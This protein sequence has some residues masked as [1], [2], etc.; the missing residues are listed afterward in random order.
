MRCEIDEE[1]PSIDKTLAPRRNS[2]ESN[3]KSWASDTVRSLKLGI[4][5]KEG[6]PPLQQR[7]IYQGKV[8]ECG[9]TL[10]EYKI[11][12]KALVLRSVNL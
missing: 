7:L 9:R 1:D 8:I 5:K 10:C 6:I 3:S 12:K 11:G 4:C 2:N